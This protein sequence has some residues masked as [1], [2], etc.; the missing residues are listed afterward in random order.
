[1]ELTAEAGQ[2]TFAFLSIGL[3]HV[4]ERKRQEEGMVVRLV[5]SNERKLSSK[6]VEW[7][8]ID[9]LAF[10][11]CWYRVDDSCSDNNDNKSQLTVVVRI[12]KINSDDKD[13]D[14]DND[15]S[16]V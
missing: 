4:V 13:D 10:N 1:M 16:T 15:S 14:H 12:T 7:Q 9:H 6:T 2:S 3:I 5:I 11:I 8:M